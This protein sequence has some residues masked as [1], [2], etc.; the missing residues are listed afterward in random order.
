MLREPDP[1]PV[2]APMPDAESM[3]FRAP[4]FGLGD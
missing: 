1:P 2:E 4:Q 3:A